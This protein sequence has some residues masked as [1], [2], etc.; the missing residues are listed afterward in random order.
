MIEVQNHGF[1]FEDWVKDTLGVKNLA[2]NYTQKWDVLGEMPISVKCMG[3]KNALEFGS[4]VRI[5]EINETFTIVIGRWKQIKNKK[6]I[7]SID[8]INITPKILKKMKGEITLTEIKDF[9]KR[10]K[11]FPAGKKEQKR[12]IEFARRW[13]LERKNRMGLLTITHKIDSKK[14]RRVQC[15]LNYSNYVQLF[16][17]PST[18]AIFRECLYIQKINHGPRVFNS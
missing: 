15:N 4:A 2:Y 3:L 9:D 1:V 12:G 10:I 13:K 8:E 5:W 11:S 7:K 16:G 17:Q 6:I 14:Q 18:D